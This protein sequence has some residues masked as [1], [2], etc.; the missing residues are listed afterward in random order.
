MSAADEY[1]LLSLTITANEIVPRL[2]LAEDVRV[3]LVWLE[4][5][6]YGEVID[7]INDACEFTTCV[8]DVNS[9]TVAPRIGWLLKQVALEPE[10]ANL[11]W[12]PRDREWLTQ[13]A[14]IA[15]QEHMAW[16]PRA[17]GDMALH[18]RVVS[19]WKLLLEVAGARVR[20]SGGDPMR[21]AL[22]LLSQLPHTRPLWNR[23]SFFCEYVT[24]G[25]QSQGYSPA[26]SLRWR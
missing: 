14:A 16:Y 6:G 1:R 7:H 26:A 22:D 23:P 15:C 20:A 10:L 11:P 18:H 2:A 4:K 21:G 9:S 25:T 8:A 13:E 5:H 12:P 17:S 3:M 19:A 24:A